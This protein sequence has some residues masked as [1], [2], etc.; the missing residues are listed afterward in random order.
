MSTS[1]HGVESTEQQAR[2]DHPKG[3]DWLIQKCSVGQATN[4]YH[5]EASPSQCIRARLLITEFLFSSQR[6]MQTV[7]KKLIFAGAIAFSAIGLSS[8]AMA[9]HVDVVVPVPAYS[10]PVVVV[11]PP[12]VYVAPPARVYF[13]A[14][15]VVVGWHANQYWDGHRYWGRDE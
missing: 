15:A 11:R 6:Q 10:P 13:A 1:N 12:P 5:G 3:P 14:P 8:P 9:V 7:T 4:L 2:T